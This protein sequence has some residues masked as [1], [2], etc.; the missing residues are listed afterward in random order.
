MGQAF[1]LQKPSLPEPKRTTP[2]PTAGPGPVTSYLLVSS[3][4]VMLHI[5]ILSIDTLFRHLR[6]VS[7]KL[8][9]EIFV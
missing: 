4:L 8:R 6:P 9:E 5:L 1:P 7:M 2:A 3:H